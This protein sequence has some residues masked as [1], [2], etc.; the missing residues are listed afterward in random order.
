MDFGPRPM[1][2]LR[3]IAAAAVLA[4]LPACGGDGPTP[5][6]GEQGFVTRQPA[7]AAGVNG[8]TVQPILSVGDT[9][10]GGLVWA[11]SPDGLGGYLEGTRLV[12]FANH[13]LGGVMG[14]DGQLRYTT[15][16]VDHALRLLMGLPS[17][18][19]W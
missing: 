15:A 5:P 18:S 16:R 9:L 19:S 7:L 3:G 8:A 17:A 10:P 14:T 4:A 13:E 2:A 1:R 6:R 12:L 11:P